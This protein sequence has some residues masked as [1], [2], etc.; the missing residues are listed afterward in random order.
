MALQKK[1]SVVQET[2][3]N[4]DCFDFL[5]SVVVDQTNTKKL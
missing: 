5:F 2:N 4:W 3:Q 1:I